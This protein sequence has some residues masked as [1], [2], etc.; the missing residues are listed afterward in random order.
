MNK[1]IG[2]NIQEIIF[3]FPQFDSDFEFSNLF[4]HGILINVLLS[5]SLKKLIPSTKSH[6]VV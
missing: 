1:E 3:W 2:E 6:L 5:F 4:Y